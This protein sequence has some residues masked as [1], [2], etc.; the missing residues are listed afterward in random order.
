MLAPKSEYGYSRE[1]K[2]G[3]YVKGFKKGY[4]EGLKVLFLCAVDVI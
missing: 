1:V 2:T 3:D 4:A